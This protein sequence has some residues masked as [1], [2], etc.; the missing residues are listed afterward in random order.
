[1]CPRRSLWPNLS[2]F[3]KLHEKGQS[4]RIRLSQDVRIGSNWQLEPSKSRSQKQ[5]CL[6]VP[7][8][9]KAFV[10]HRPTHFGQCGSLGSGHAPGATQAGGSWPRLHRG[11][12]TGRGTAAHP[13]Y[14]THEQRRNHHSAHEHRGGRKNTAAPDMPP[15]RPRQSQRS[16]PHDTRGTATL[17]RRPHEAQGTGH[18]PTAATPTQGDRSRAHGGHT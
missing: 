4:G 15:R 1:M 5:P 8:G 10:P 17:P 11:S 3:V 18:A 14:R 16:P 6:Q 9:P 2:L 13:N 7:H 12:I